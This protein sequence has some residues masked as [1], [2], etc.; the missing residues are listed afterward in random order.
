MK[1]FTFTLIALF[2]IP[3]V[4]NAITF[5]MDENEL[6]YLYETYQ[7][8]TSTGTYL[9]PVQAL[10]NGAKFT[11]NVRTSESGW[12]QIQIGANY[13]GIPWGGSA[14]DEPT[15]M[16]L[17][18]GSLAGFDKY[19]QVFENLNEST[20]EYN[21]YF[22]IGWTDAPASET[23]YY[24]QNHWTS[25]NAG[26]YKV[27]SLDFSNAQVWGGAY[28]GDWV[29]LS[30]IGDLDLMHV[31]NIGFN[32]GGNM[33]VDCE[34]DFTFETKVTAIPEP[35]TMVLVGLGMLGLGITRKLRK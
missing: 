25:I 11:G 18:M 5:T 35:T 2:L 15:N 16:A 30:T 23:N 3:V 21:L 22:N 32:I 31:S 12:G 17:G 1:R 20:W 10:S 34:D 28:S 27:L 14:G 9:N 29:D 13:W 4:A 8:P 26:D 33:P 7:N 19:S 24:V 6:P